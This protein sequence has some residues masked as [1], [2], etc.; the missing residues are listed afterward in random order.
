MWH[1]ARA[2]GQPGLFDLSR[3]FE[4]LYEEGSLAEFLDLKQINIACPMLKEWYTNVL[5][6]RAEAMKD[7]A[8]S[9]CLFRAAKRQGQCSTRFVN[10]RAAFSLSAAQ[11]DFTPINP[12]AA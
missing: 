11:T 10:V 7:G 9:I 12:H 4:G 8:C 5:R 3:L 2:M 6:S 1:K